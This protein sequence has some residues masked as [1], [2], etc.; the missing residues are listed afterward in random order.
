MSEGDTRYE[1]VNAIWATVAP[2]PPC[3]RQEAEKAVMLLCHRFGKRDGGPWQKRDYAPSKFRR[4]WIDLKG[5]GGRYSL[6][7]G[8]GRIVHDLSHVIYDKRVGP[9]LRRRHSPQHARFELELAQYV[10]DSGW[11]QGK[12]KPKAPTPP[13]RDNRR[14]RLAHT[15]E[16][17]KRWSTKLKRA[18]TALKK[19]DRRRRVLEKSL[20]QT[21]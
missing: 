9:E 17:I 7:R 21:P 1:P 14:E 13:P 16:A 2:L 12:L 10:V 5:E 6:M 15:D 4:C 18:T 19:L 3:T 20:E 8:W 11:L